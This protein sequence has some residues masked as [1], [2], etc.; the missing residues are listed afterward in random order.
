MESKPNHTASRQQI[1]DDFLSH[2][3]GMSYLVDVPRGKKLRARMAR[4]KISPI[5]TR[6]WWQRMKIDRQQK[7][8][9]DLNFYEVAALA[10]DVYPCTN[11]Q[12]PDHDP[13]DPTCSALAVG[14]WCK[15]CERV[16]M[17]SQQWHHWHYGAPEGSR[18]ILNELR[19][20]APDLYAMVDAKLQ[21]ER[22]SWKD[23]LVLI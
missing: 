13:D 17:L 23:V 3:L 14:S 7:I 2:F 6:P 19:L 1:R 15:H 21:S 18:Y 22:L 11:T 4:T 10:R 20:S 16:E 5:P 8:I 9:I 12:H